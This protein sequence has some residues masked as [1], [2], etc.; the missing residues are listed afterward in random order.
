MSDPDNILGNAKFRKE[1]LLLEAAWR[2]QIVA[3]L[4]SSKVDSEFKSR[5]RQRSVTEKQLHP[6]RGEISVSAR[7]LRR[8]CQ[9]YRKEQLDGLWLQPRVDAGLSREI[10]AEAIEHAKLLFK[11]NPRRSVPTLIRLLAIE[12][13]EWA[14][15]KRTTL[16]RHLRAA[17]L[18]RGSQDTKSYLKFQATEGN[19]LWQGDVLH[20]PKVSVDGK[21][22]TAKVVSWL[23]DY[24][25]FV[26]HLEAFDNE[27]LPVLEHTLTRA[28]AKHGKPHSLLVD[29]GKIYAS[30]TFTLACS[31][32]GIHKIHSAPYHPESKGKQERFFRTLRDQLLNEVEMVEPLS[33]QRLNGLLESWLTG[34]HA[35]VHSQTETT[36]QERYRDTES[37]AVPR[38][39]L[40]EAFLQWARRK[41][42]TQGVVE[43]SG[44]DYYVDPSFAGQ[45]ILVRYNP[46][47]LS[48]I[49]LWK[50]GRK[51]CHATPETLINKTLARKAS[52][53]ESSFSAA[54]R[55]Y[56]ESIEKAH[57]KK[58]EAE[59]NLMRLEDNQG[60]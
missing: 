16:G 57:Q 13:P 7:S 15:I 35:R 51:L 1:Q 26:V 29:N 43:F 22:V 39:L 37:F 9:A 48:R 56:L 34:Y 23:D 30:N 3:P 46:F 42:T 2:Y 36:P 5:H 32:L 20:G 54:S 28:I 44:Q 10:P 53:A 6:F 58:L 41:V 52:N 59:L 60:E 47:D 27:R 38:E 21:I 17:G 4:L 14:T 24:S 55:R 19:R 45:Q 49:W 25:R 33:L 31:Q 18:R 40:E 11:E 50:D 12:K 8:W